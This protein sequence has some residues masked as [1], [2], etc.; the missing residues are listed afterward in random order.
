MGLGDAMSSPG[1][2]LGGDFDF[3]LAY[4]GDPF[5]SYLSGQCTQFCS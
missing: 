1:K 5:L 2:G 3:G 4:Q